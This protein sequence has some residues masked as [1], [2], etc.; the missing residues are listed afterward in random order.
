MGYI[1]M[2]AVVLLAVIA[3]VGA[4]QRKP[5][6]TDYNDG[7]HIWVYEAIE[8]GKTCRIGMKT[9]K[10]LAG[11]VS[12]PEEITTQ[13]GA[14]LRV[15]E[16]VYRGFADALGLTEITIPN[17]VVKIDR[18]AFAKCIGLQE[19]NLPSSLDTIVSNAFSGCR[20]LTKMVIPKGVRKIMG[21]LFTSCPKLTEVKVEE[22]NANYQVTDGVLMSTDGQTLVYYPIWKEQKEYTVPSSVRTLESAAFD[23][24]VH[25]E[26]VSLPD[27]V[28]SIPGNLFHNCKNLKNVTIPN[29]VTRIEANAFSDCWALPSIQLPNSM[30]EI[31]IGAF[32]GCTA[33]TSIH[34]PYGVKTMGDAA[35]Y[36]CPALTEVFWLASEG[37]T[38]GDYPFSAYD[39]LAT[40]YVRKGL[41][42]EFERKEW[43][44]ETFSITEYPGVDFK[45]ADGTMLDAQLVKPNEKAKQ[46]SPAP[47][48]SGFLFKGWHL[49]GNPYDFNTPVE[50]NITLVA[51]WIAEKRTIT[52][53]A[54]GGDPTPPAQEVD[55]GQN[56]KL[57]SP[58]PQKSGF[59]FKGWSLKGNLY[60]FNTP[61]KSNI[62][63]VAQWEKASAVES[64]LLE[65]ATVAGNPFGE[66]LTLLGL[67]H[68]E[69]ISVYSVI[70]VPVY[71]ASLRGETHIALN[72]TRWATGVYL[73]RITARDG[74]KVLRVV[75]R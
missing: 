21:G 24:C 72:T 59:L 55:Y 28:T 20:G 29:G 74:A 13:D 37:C 23:S 34:I 50:D 47:Q 75:K 68:A 57:P 54:D 17:G 41:Q 35:F 42:G 9:P 26:K 60:D 63:L 38:V 22:G 65:G 53:D 14:V 12:I 7:K 33:L 36:G 18:E 45:D 71:T 69:R 56:A 66:T 10:D 70:G 1:K 48:K 46:P 51:Q 15:V 49:N 32:S 11:K 31:G 67:A 39:P 58:A 64:V 6:Y 61:V 8:P 19:I 43:I 25:L 3:N 62:T 4:A 27:G 2:A 5:N 73:I 44:K 40:L 30:T 16:I 52:F